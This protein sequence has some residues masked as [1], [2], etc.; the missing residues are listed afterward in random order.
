[1][2]GCHVC[3]MLPTNGY[4]SKS[5]S[6]Q[7][8]AMTV[9]NPTNKVGMKCGDSRKLVSQNEHNL[10]LSTKSFVYKTH[11]LWLNFVNETEFRYKIE[12]CVS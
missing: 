11:L 10:Q 6:K 12:S 3:E 8:M 9:Q 7:R 1:M 5:S 4:E 2:V